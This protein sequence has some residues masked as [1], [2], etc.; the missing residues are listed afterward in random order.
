MAIQNQTITVLYIQCRTFT[1][2]SAKKISTCSLFLFIHLIHL[3]HGK[4]NQNAQK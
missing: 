1:M 4:K 3:E 2:C